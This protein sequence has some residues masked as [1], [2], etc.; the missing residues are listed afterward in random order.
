MYGS[1]LSDILG[2]PEN[3]KSYIDKKN[4]LAD[5]ELNRKRKNSMDIEEKS[6][7]LIISGN[8]KNIGK[9]L[10]AN[11]NMIKFLSYTEDSMYEAYLSQFVPKPFDRSHDIRLLKFIEESTSNHVFRS[12]PLFLLNKNGFL[13]EC[14]FNSE[15]IGYEGNINFLALVEPITSKKREVGIISTEGEIFCHSENFPNLLGCT[16]RSIEGRYINEFLCGIIIANLAINSLYMIKI[17]SDTLKQYLNLGIIIKEK[18]IGST[19]FIV[20]YASSEESEIL[21]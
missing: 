7:L 4:R 2:D 6:C 1:L 10:Y 13:V 15:G 21:K 18:V 9:I 8:E 5:N 19:S 17:N 11:S 12:V 20:M 14:Y 16:A 3:G